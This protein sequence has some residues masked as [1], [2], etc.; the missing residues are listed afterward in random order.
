VYG[1]VW[2]RETRFD[3]VMLVIDKD[4]SLHNKNI[5]PLPNDQTV[6]GVVLWAGQILIYGESDNPV[7]G[8]D[9]Y[10]L[11]FDIESIL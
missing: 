10:V 9:V 8:K 7:T 1:V 11:A 3:P 2:N 5:I 4:A 6:R